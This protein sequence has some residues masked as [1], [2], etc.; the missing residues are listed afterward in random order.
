MDSTL[1]DETQI[2]DNFLELFIEEPDSKISISDQFRVKLYSV[3]CK[4]DKSS[5]SYTLGAETLRFDF[6]LE[7]SP[8]MAVERQITASVL[9]SESNAFTGGISFANFP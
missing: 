6:E 1:A 7:Q 3:T 5:Y 9:D 2:G 8:D 4:T